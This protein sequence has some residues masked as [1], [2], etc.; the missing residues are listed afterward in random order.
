MT[1]E[2]KTL[3]EK[4]AKRRQMLIVFYRNWMLGIIT[5]EECNKAAEEFADSI[6]SLLLKEVEVARLN[7]DEIKTALGYKM[8]AVLLMDYG[9]VAA[10]Q[11]EA[12]KKI[13]GK[14]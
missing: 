11:L 13:L 3:R 9:K 2:Q 5:T 4:I 6:L 7:D 1:E 8:G 12:V 10:A 14:V